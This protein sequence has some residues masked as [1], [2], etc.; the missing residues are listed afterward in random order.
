MV[1]VPGQ[2]PLSTPPQVRLRQ[3]MVLVYASLLGSSAAPDLLG[4]ASQVPRYLLTLLTRHG[5]LTDCAR[6]LDSLC[7]PLTMPTPHYAHPSLC[8]SLTMPIPRYAHPSLCPPLA[9]PIPHYARHR[10]R[11]QVLAVEHARVTW[12]SPLSG[13]SGGAR[14]RYLV[15]TPVRC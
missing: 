13:A 10:K 6:Y 1:A 9:M 2:P 7:P 12:L 4:L 11:S 15:I 3:A 14:T 5:T 8:P